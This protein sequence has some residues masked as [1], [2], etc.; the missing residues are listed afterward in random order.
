MNENVFET[1]ENTVN[2]DCALKK[3]VAQ[4]FCRLLLKAH[5]H[6]WW[7]LIQGNTCSIYL[8]IFASGASVCVCAPVHVDACLCVCVWILVE[9]GSAWAL[10]CCCRGTAVALAAAALCKCNYRADAVWHPNWGTLTV[11]YDFGLSV[12]VCISFCHQILPHPGEA[13]SLR[14]DATGNNIAFLLANFEI[15]GSLAFHTFVSV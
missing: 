1:N 9:E 2:T 12:F 3:P 10:S 15:L 6:Q 4:S 8:F 14:Q 13:F 5:C 7:Y 11:F